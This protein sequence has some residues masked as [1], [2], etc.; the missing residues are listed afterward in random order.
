M[1]ITAEFHEPEI[2]PQRREGVK[3]RKEV[4]GLWGF[5]AGVLR[6]FAPLRSVLTFFQPKEQK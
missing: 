4:Q 3:D 2:P 1:W 5:F 6:A